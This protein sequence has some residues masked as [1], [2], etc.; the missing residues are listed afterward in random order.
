ML[1]IILPFLTD[2]DQRVLHSVGLSPRWGPLLNWPLWPLTLHRRRFGFGADNPMVSASY[3]PNPN[4]PGSADTPLDVVSPE[5]LGH[6]CWDFLSVVDRINLVRSSPVFVFYHRLRL[7]AAQG[8]SLASCRSPPRLD[9]D[10]PLPFR[11][12]YLLSVA[13]CK[14]NF[15]YA[16]MFRWLGGTYNNKHRSLQ[17]TFDVIDRVKAFDPHDRTWRLFHQGAPLTGHFSF[18]RTSVAARNLFDNYSGV[19]ENFDTILAKYKKEEQL[20]YHL[21]LPCIMWRFLPGLFIALINW[22]APKPH[23]LG[24]TGRLCIDPSSKISVSDDGNPNSPIPDAGLDPDANPSVAYGTAFERFLRYVYNLR[25][26]HPDEDI[27]LSADDISAAFRRVNYNPQVA[28]VFSCVL[29]C[30]LIIPVG[31]IFG[32]K[33]SPSYY[34]TPGELRAHLARHLPSLND[35]RTRLGDS[36]VLPPP[37]TPTD[38]ATFVRVE[39]DDLNTGVSALLASSSRKP[40]YA[41]FVDD[42]GG[43]AIRA[44]I[45]ALVHNSILAAYITF[46]VPEED[47]GRP[48]PIN[49][50]K[51]V[52]QLSHQL[53]FL[54]FF[55][56]TRTMSITWPQHTRDQLRLY[57]TNLLDTDETPSGGRRLSPQ[58]AATILGLV[59]H[60]ATATL[61]GTYYTL[62]LQFSLNDNIRSSVAQGLNPASTRFWQR[63]HFSLSR[64]TILDLRALLHFLPV[65]DSDHFWSRPIGLVIPRESQFTVLGDASIEGLGG[66]LNERFPFMWR[67]TK[68]DLE[69]IG[70]IIPKDMQAIKI[71]AE[72]TSD[73][74]SEPW[75]INLLE[76]IVLI[77]D[78]WFIQ[79]LAPQR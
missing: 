30:F 24:D 75:H 25:L 58:S 53:K 3:A 17:P 32:A 74:T 43:A 69:A 29:D 20:Q 26:D 47:P 68:S 78:F 38:V 48:E 2:T 12:A 52:R 72:T 13:L 6:F 59:R 51:F 45:H 71:T 23:Q 19:Y 5:L 35:A 76:F 54:G 61:L 41:P 10:A 15:V 67:L 64:E 27:L 18:G 22:V 55:I 40:A 42:T 4:K 1:A 66:W 65:S 49:P 60:S 56:D 34:M 79:V 39:Q 44:N 31:M 37:P 57:L 50:V 14:Q 21:F 9:P 36:I 11:K 73:T 63:T 70:F 77:I 8:V 46:G 28:V 16:D 62:S 33:N 7:S